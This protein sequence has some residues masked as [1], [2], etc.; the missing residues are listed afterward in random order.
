VH[1]KVDSRRPVW[2]MLRE[3]RLRWYPAGMLGHERLQP[4][5]R[6]ERHDAFHILLNFSTSLEEAMQFFL[7]GNGNISPFNLAA[8]FTALVMPD[9]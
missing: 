6:G 1:A 2:G 9:K 3:D 8:A 5:D 4:V 7:V